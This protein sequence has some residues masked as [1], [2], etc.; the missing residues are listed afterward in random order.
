MKRPLHLLGLVL[1]TLVL[2][3]ATTVGCSCGSDTS[4]I[5]GGG[6]GNNNGT[7]G[8]DGGT[9]FTGL[10]GG[11]NADAITIS[12][13][14]PVIDVEMGM[15]P[16]PTVQF[17]ALATNGGAEV[18]AQWGL[19]SIA[20][21]SI[22]NGGMFTANGLAGGKIT[23]TATHGQAKATTTL[24]INFHAKEGT[25]D[26]ND[27]TILKGPGGQSDPNFVLWYPYDKTIFPRGI[28]PPQ[29]HPSP[30]GAGPVSKYYLHITATGYEYEGF[31]D[32]VAQLAQSQIA[33]DA[34]GGSSDG[35][36]VKV[37]LS[38]LVGGQ[39][40]GPIMQTWRVA[41]GK[42]HGT[43]Y[44]NTYDS[45]LAGQTGAMM[46]I[47]GNSPSPEVLVGNCTVCHS[48]SSDGS[49]AAA[50]NHSGPGG[51]FDL[52]GGNVNPPLGYTTPEEAAFAALYPKNGPDMVFV[53]NGAP[54]GFWP[55]NTPGTQ[56]QW[57]SSLHMKNGTVVP[58][59]GI[60]SYYAQSPVFSHDGTMIA[61]CDR[62]AG[63]GP[64]KL[65][66]MHYDKATLKFT[67]YEVL[68]T[69]GS[70]HF[71]WPAF[72]PDNKYVVYQAGTADDLA[73]WSGTSKL[74][75]V[76]VQTKVVTELKALNGDGYMPGAGQGSGRDENLNF[77]PTILPIGSGGYFWIMFTSRRTYGNVLTGGSGQTKRLW[78]SAFDI[79][80]QDGVDPTHPGFYI[81]GQELNSGNSRG[82]WAL[83]PCKNNGE[84]CATGDEC[85]EGACTPDPADPSKFT[86]SPPG[87]CS[88]EFDNCTTDGDCC[89]AAL[90]CIGGKCTQLP[91]N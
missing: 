39:K 78:V 60:E 15:S 36:D 86:C 67:N 22:N 79:N 17:K 63:G 74:F 88:N 4:A 85:C 66:L 29:L 75:A 24:T 65:A 32:G 64:S 62:P 34:L 21:G 20:A 9:S 70:G 57:T 30:S 58:A 6:G 87:D 8:G 13:T 19:S 48:V 18:S 55:P 11:I 73:T 84:G 52:S 59:S 68:A 28:L 35:G 71:A 12:P 49:T 41:T 51:I 76:N 47:K 42:L 89:D 14:D 44:Y 26:P 90:K 10:G 16:T 5:N 2:S 1:G 45:M 27:E 72:T 91:P 53:V 69:P 81:S 83:D 25:V 54:G 40:Y 61:F 80:A 33:W 7:G 46:R 43:I 77:E 23:V 3:A 37:E 82:F 56:G 38:K 50:A 31:F